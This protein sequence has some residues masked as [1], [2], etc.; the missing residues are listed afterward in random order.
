[1]QFTNIILS[2]L[3]TG[4]LLCKVGHVPLYYSEWHSAG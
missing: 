4:Y 2:L 1:M 3:I